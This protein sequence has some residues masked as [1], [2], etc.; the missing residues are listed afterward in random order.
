MYWMCLLYIISQCSFSD[1]ESVQSI[2]MELK[3]TIASIIIERLLLKEKKC[4]SCKFPKVRWGRH[5]CF[6][7]I[8]VSLYLPYL[9]LQN[10]ICGHVINFAE[11]S[12][13]YWNH[14][15]KV[16]QQRQISSFFWWRVWFDIRGTHAIWQGRWGFIQ[17]KSNNHNHILG[18]VLRFPF[19]SPC[20]SFW[21][22]YCSGCGYRVYEKSRAAVWANW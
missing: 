13:H 14:E 15:K 16:L 22:I 3:K 9:F 5:W 11:V 21:Q 12:W 1:R 19:L 18:F 2:S 7:N 8:V 17:L 6:I 20:V 10:W 4:E